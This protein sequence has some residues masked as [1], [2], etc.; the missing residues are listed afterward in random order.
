MVGV[1]GA[2]P[3]IVWPCHQL[4][5]FLRV[6]TPAGVCHVSRVTHSPGSYLVLMSIE[7]F[8]IMNEE[9]MNFKELK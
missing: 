5:S 7:D 9:K 4:I 6:V 8:N 3:S 2:Q 1:S